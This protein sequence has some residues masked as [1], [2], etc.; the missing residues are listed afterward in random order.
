MKKLFA[1]FLALVFVSAVTLPSVIFADDKADDKM[2]VKKDTAADDM[3]KEDKSKE[4]D[5]SMEKGDKPEKKAMKNK[6]KS[7]KMAKVKK[8]KKA[9]EN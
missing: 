8:K 5:E 6:K 1:L 2:E 9:A 4:G 3:D 7:K